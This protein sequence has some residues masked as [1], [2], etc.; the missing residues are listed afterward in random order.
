MD[1]IYKE[2]LDK[3][4]SREQVIA[5]P[6]EVYKDKKIEVLKHNSRSSEES[7]IDCESLRDS[8]LAG[9]S[10][11]MTRL[12]ASFD[13]LA[14]SEEGQVPQEARG[15][16]ITPAITT[17]RELDYSGISCQHNKTKRGVKLSILLQTPEG[18]YN[19]V[20]L[21]LTAELKR[22]DRLREIKDYAMDDD[23]F[24][25]FVR[26]TLNDISDLDRSVRDNVVA[27]RIHDRGVR[28]AW[29][30]NAFIVAKMDNE[31]ITKVYLYLEQE[32][33]EIDMNIPL[34]PIQEKDYYSS[35]HYG[36][37]VLTP[38]APSLKTAQHRK[39]MGGK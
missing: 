39:I 12:A 26:T 17:S 34:S 10:P 28:A 24:K 7:Q 11:S 13:L 25:K 23:Y 31:I 30:Q 32:E 35:G 6:R 22:S 37:V 3:I 36:Q 2:I 4:N 8:S 5:N 19:G 29:Y 9:A 38:V 21:Q 15:I 16:V 33:Y 20:G 18:K 27:G 1:P 14:E